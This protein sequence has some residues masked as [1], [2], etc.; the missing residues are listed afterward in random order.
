VIQAMQEAIRNHTV[1]VVV[2]VVGKRRVEIYKAI[3]TRWSFLIVLSVNTLLNWLWKNT[4][5]YRADL[6]G[7]FN[8]IR[9][10][11]FAQLFNLALTG[12][13][14]SSQPGTFLF[15][16]NR[17]ASIVC[18]YLEEEFIRT[19][20]R[21][22][23]KGTVIAGLQTD[24]LGRTKLIGRWCFRTR[25]GLND[26]AFVQEPQASF[27]DDLTIVLYFVHELLIRQINAFV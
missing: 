26:G 20:L 17:V 14:T 3:R 16:N 7:W 24:G 11:H 9:P 13:T 10:R 27:R 22:F 19:I 8:P 23:S 4:A 5:S 1:V 21:Q 12:N 18:L 6:V 2:V 25:P 15:Q